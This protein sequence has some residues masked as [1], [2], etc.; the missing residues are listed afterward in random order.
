MEK[1]GLL[2]LKVTGHKV[3]R[4]VEVKRGESTDRIDVQ[5]ESYSVFRPTQVQVK[6][7]K[8]TNAAGH[9]GYK[10]LSASQYLTLVWRSSSANYLM[11]FMYPILFTLC[12]YFI[13]FIF[14]VMLFRYEALLSREDPGP[15][16]T[17]VVR[18]GEWL[19]NGERDSL[20]D[21]VVMRHK[22][23]VTCATAITFCDEVPVASSQVLL[24]KDHTMGE[25]NL[26]RMI[27]M[28]STSFLHEF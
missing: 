24:S 16:Q 17:S 1:R 27:T 21:R 10:A 19:S 26:L 22:E 18:E 13:P 23:R 2:D 14:F 12:L 5:H 7:L 25:K 4:P 6:S 11:V 9:I 3:D 8:Q 20:P 28:M 15:C